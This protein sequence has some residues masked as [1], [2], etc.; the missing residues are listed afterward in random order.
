MT[1]TEGLAAMIERI[2]QCEALAD[3]APTTE[4]YLRWQGKADLWRSRVS[5]SRHHEEAIHRAKARRI[6]QYDAEEAC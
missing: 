5:L 2:A 6:A 1:I 3:T 4:E